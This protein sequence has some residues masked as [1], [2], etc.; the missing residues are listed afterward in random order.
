MSF[1]PALG[2]LASAGFMLIYPLKEPF[3]E[4]IETELAARRAAS[5]KPEQAAS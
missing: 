1:Y 5:G 3:M 2:A 4:K